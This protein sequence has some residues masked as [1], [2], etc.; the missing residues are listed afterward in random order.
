MADVAE[1]R[2]GGSAKRGKSEK[3]L[4]IQAAFEAKKISCQT[5]AL[6]SVMMTSVHNCSS[7]TEQNC[8]QL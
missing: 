2:K 3:Q 4:T 5:Q 6:I 1:A 8:E 7:L